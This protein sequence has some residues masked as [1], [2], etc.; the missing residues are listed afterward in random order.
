MADSAEAAPQ[1]AVPSEPFVALDHVNV[2]AG[3]SWDE[4]LQQFWFDILGAVRDPRGDE[5][6]RQ[7]RE[8]GASFGGLVFANLGLQQFH[9][10]LG[11]KEYPVQVLRG[12]VGIEYPEGELGAAEERLSRAAYPFE[13]VSRSPTVLELTEPNGTLLRLHGRGE[14]AGVSYYAAVEP[15]ARGTAPCLPGGTTAALGM[16][17]V[18]MWCP[19]GAASG[20]A[21]FYRDVFG[22][23]ADVEG[24]ASGPARATVHIGHRQQLR[25]VERDGELPAYDGHHVALYVNRFQALYQACAGRALVW[26]NPR[27]P[28]LTYDTLEDAVTRHEFRIKDIVDLDT[29]DVLL[30]L[31]HEIR[32]LSHPGYAACLEIAASTD[33][34]GER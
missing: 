14:D 22:A 16:P 12:V 28:D 7:R 30:T 32:P 2:N 8:A 1:I 29:G 11:E 34:G 13:V 25:F 18:E 10:P 24:T 3:D 26:N 4:S 20:I 5:I 31:E 33:S 9:F 19:R 27:F 21:K 15:L 23:A 17:Y 6:S